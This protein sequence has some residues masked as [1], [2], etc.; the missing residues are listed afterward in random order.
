MTALANLKEKLFNRL[1]SD[2]VGLSWS[3]QTMQVIRLKRSGA[4]LQIVGA[5][6]LLL[7]EDIY[8]A[9][10]KI[11]AV[12]LNARTRGRYA[13]LCCPSR[14]EAVKLLR[15]PES[16]DP[17]NRDELLS[18]LTIDPGL[19][20]RIAHRVLAPGAA[21]TE[22]RI[23][24]GAMPEE[25]ATRLMQ[26]MPATGMPAA[27]SL[28]L[29]E[30]AVMNAFHNDP[31]FVDNEKACGLIHFD[32]AY[33]LIALYNEGILSQLRIFSFGVDAVLSKV[34]QALNVDQPT[35]QG[36][37]MDGA[38]D[39]SHLIEE[40][41]RDM[42]SQLVICRDFMERS[43]NCALENLYI[44]GPASLTRPFISGMSV[45]ENVTE[46]NV[47]EPYPEATPGAVPEELAAEPWRM[48]AAL[49][50]A[51]GVLSPS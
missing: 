2:V 18:R 8:A 39:L 26:C 12:A 24:A 37:L 50:A 9:P 3:G 1:P 11:S 38:F 10:E 16:F 22:A 6:S 51:L 31:R 35:A 23:L 7:E 4:S 34:M 30:I 27:R 5:D 13:A 45:P 40:G 42:R 20:V 33:S 14:R 25:Q 36:V 32:E 43:E 21:K 47:L 15:V 49:G 46:W 44:S 19:A 41:F 28:E 17:A 48:A 29:A